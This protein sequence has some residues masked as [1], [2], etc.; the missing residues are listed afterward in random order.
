ME[1]SV[2]T[3]V[4]GFKRL[5]PTDRDR[6]TPWE[7]TSQSLQHL[8]S[9]TGNSFFDKDPASVPSPAE[10]TGDVPSL[11]SPGISLRM[12][13]TLLLYLREQRH[14]ATHRGGAR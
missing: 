11:I 3:L 6:Q 14:P 4:D 12:T 2:T 1:Y 8:T 7:H 10:T 13:A 9:T 5:T